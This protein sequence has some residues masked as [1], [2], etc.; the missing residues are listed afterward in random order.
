[1][2]EEVRI[3]ILFDFVIYRKREDFYQKNLD[4]DIAE[5]R[6]KHFQSRLIDTINRVLD[7]RRNLSTLYHINTILEIKEM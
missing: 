1:M 3:L 4:E 5:L 6:F 2:L 7:E